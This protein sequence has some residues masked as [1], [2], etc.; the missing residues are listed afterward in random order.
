M[1]E[2][3]KLVKKGGRIM[4]HGGKTCVHIIILGHEKEL[5]AII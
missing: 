5:S 4:Y 2:E 3:F 1:V